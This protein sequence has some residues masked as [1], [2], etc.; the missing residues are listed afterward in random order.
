MR[1]D[2]ADLD[3]SPAIDPVNHFPKPIR[4]LDQD[5]EE[6]DFSEGD[7]DDGIDEGEQDQS[8]NALIPK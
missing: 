6:D 2:P 5:V 4:L 8:E 3:L 1:S 7:R